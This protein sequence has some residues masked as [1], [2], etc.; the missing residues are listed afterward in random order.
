AENASLGTSHSVSSKKLVNT[1]AL[2]SIPSC[3]D[4][5]DY[6]QPGFDPN[7]ATRERLK[8]ILH[9]HEIDFPPNPKKAILVAL[10]KDEIEPRACAT[11]KERDN[12]KPSAKGIIDM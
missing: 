9:A 10:F 6:L 5:V 12:I 4:N 1:A 11:L 3:D 8:N 2:E 7:K